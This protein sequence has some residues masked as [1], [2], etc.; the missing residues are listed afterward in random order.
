MLYYFSP[1][2]VEFH[3]QCDGHHLTNSEINSAI[4]TLSKEKLASYF[5]VALKDTDTTTKEEVSAENLGISK[6]TKHNRFNH[7]CS[8]D[9]TS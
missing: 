7:L 6:S 1:K 8:V 3:A 4:R 9:S 2:T 5:P